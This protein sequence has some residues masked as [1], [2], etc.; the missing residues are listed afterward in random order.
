MST[1]TNPTRST[2]S[3]SRWTV[4]KRAGPRSSPT[5]QPDRSRLHYPEASPRCT[6]NS[7][8]PSTITGSRITQHRHAH[9]QPEDEHM[10]FEDNT[11]PLTTAAGAPVV[12]NQNSM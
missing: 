9:H 11:E 2:W 5:N 6:P 7:L 8:D 1:P 4:W 10:G 12:D 3:E